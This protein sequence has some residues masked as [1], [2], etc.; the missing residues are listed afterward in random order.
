M[1]VPFD[2]TQILVIFP[3]DI[4]GPQGHGVAR[5]ALDTGATETTISRRALRAVGIDPAQANVGSVPVIT[6]SGV[7]SVPLVT[8]NRMDALG[9]Q[10][11]GFTVQAHT[12]PSSLPIDGV[13]GLDFIRGYRLVVDFRT[14]RISLT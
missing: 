7:I 13:L 2:T 11:S 14:G 9:R 10:R 12:L 3:V 1:R 4:Y 5:L 8:L 6:G